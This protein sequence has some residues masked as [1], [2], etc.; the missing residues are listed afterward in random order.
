MKARSLDSASLRSPVRDALGGD[1]IFRC[2]ILDT[3]YS[4]QLAPPPREW[5][6]IRR[7][8]VLG[9]I[10][11]VYMNDGTMANANIATA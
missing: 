2:L 11:N 5:G 3:R 10:I 6:Y 4:K 8:A 9:V 7:R 1:D